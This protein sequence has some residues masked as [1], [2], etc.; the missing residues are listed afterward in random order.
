ML[1]QFLFEP[2]SAVLA[3]RLAG[4][5]AARHELTAIASGI[6]YFTGPRLIAEPLMTAF[7]IIDSLPFDRRTLGAY[8]RERN[9]GR[10]EIKHRGLTLDPDRLRK[11][12]KLRGDDAAVLIVTKLGRRAAVFVAQRVADGG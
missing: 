5:L 6:A 11:E 4:A 12:L 10:V 2:D 7:D 3:A 8:L 9:V 1:D